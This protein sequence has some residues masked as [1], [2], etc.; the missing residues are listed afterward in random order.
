MKVIDYEQIKKL[1]ISYE[2]YYNWAKEVLFLKRECQLPPKISMKKENHIFTNVMP[3]IMDPIATAGVKIV[4]R[5]PNRKPSLDSQILLYDSLSGECLAI[6]DGNIITA[7][8]TAAVANIAINELA[9]I[10]YTTIAI[11]GLGNI[12]YAT[13]NILKTKINKKV[14]IKLYKYK[15]QEERFINYFQNNKNLEFHVVNT[16]EELIK[17]SD[18]IISCVTSIDVNFGEDDWYKD[19]CLV[20][21]IHT[22]GFQNCDLFFDK[23]IVDDINH[24]KNF[25]YFNQF[26]EV[27]ELADVLKNKKLGRSNSKE[28]MI[29]YNIGN[30]I[31]DVFFAKKIY[32]LLK[33]KETV[34][35]DLKP[36]KEKFWI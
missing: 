15:N 18:V 28:K 4:S 36:P 34:N 11:I 2:E 13:M 10:D 25:K 14:T 23:F 29:A 31:F 30:S 22:L 8:R 35:I 21:P 27:H 24:V 33:D 32:D 17:D 9:N 12:A 20:V 6:L 16:Y 5:Y 19:G 7:Y 1:N 3:S 26:K